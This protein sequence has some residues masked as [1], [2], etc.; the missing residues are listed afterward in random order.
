M[1]ISF[2]KYVDITSGVA[3]QSQIPGRS[4]GG[5]I[6]TPNPMAS[7]DALITATDAASVGAYF[8]TNSEEYKRAVKYFG[9]VSKLTRRAQVLQFARWQREANP[10]GIFGGANQALT[11]TQLKA[12]TA[13][14]IHFMFGATEVSV[15]AISFAAA[16]T[17]ADV[18]SELQTAL[19]LNAATE[20][21]TA[22]VTYDPV[23]ARFNF[24]GSSTDTTAESISI[25]PDV[26][27]A[28]DVATALGWQVTDGA[29][30][31]AASPV[32]TPVAQLIA[33]VT[34]NNNF[35]SFI[36][37][38]NGGVAIALSDAVAL[39]TQNN[40][41]N[42]QFRFTYGVN[43]TNFQASAAAL[44]TIGGTNVIY[45]LVAQ[46]GEYHDMQDM[47]IL[48]A[49]DF[50]QVNG[51]TGYMYVQ[52]DGQTAAVTDD[53][54]AALLDGLAINYYGQTQEDGATIMF[55]QDGVLMGGA[56]DPR[57]ANVYSNEQWLKAFAGDSF[58][59]L[60]LALA[61]LSANTNGRGLVLGKLTKEVIPAA[62]KNGT[63]SV[64]K[65]L[66]VDQQLFITELTGDDNA[67]QKVQN[68][69]F[70]YDVELSSFVGP[71]SITR[72]QASYSL[73]YS[74]D[75]LIR[76]VIGTH[77]LI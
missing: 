70:W 42:V 14:V 10:V 65:T 9:F 50:T 35:G 36:F 22:T 64:G 51:T 3:A 32:V 19:R 40:S 63:F 8:G 15:S 45:S 43:E 66:S 75:D 27:P 38:A 2:S 54:T 41:Y 67:W 24:A 52:F 29:A 18:A 13:G 55:Y 33:S 61:K 74:K 53:A 6:F 60:Q 17:L 20:L 71:A 30:Y 48:G 58:M 47:I 46:A 5:R 56:T 73:V 26:N 62:Q 4:F 23:G 72:W 69:G 16:A 77:T 44:A 76:K 49:T 25:V 68:N 59:S 21:V 39:A 28:I 12:I 57:D 1:P 11:L 37:T 7:S 34:A 31:I